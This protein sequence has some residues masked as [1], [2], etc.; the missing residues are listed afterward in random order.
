MSCTARRHV[1]PFCRVGPTASTRIPDWVA[2]RSGTV[3]DCP[4]GT[5]KPDRRQTHGSQFVVRPLRHGRGEH[6]AHGA[7][8]G[9]RRRQRH[10]VPSLE[11]AV[12]KW[13]A[14]VAVCRADDDVTAQAAM[15]AQPHPLRGG[16][17]GGGGRA[18]RW[19]TMPKRRATAGRK[20][21]CVG[22]R[23]SSIRTHR[24]RR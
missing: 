18:H 22:R 4:P 9:L 23:W 15:V 2:L 6:G 14:S 20:G 7:H 19:T 1:L 10:H 5:R 12:Q 21:G 11:P 17:P 8:P 24:R 13:A 3:E 16:D